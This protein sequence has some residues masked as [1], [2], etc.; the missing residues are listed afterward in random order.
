M[1]LL[2]QFDYDALMRQLQTGV[3]NGH[4]ISNWDTVR[5]QNGLTINIYYSDATASEHLLFDQGVNEHPEG[6]VGTPDSE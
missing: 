3:R 4:P 6:Y 1:A 2:Q 5:D